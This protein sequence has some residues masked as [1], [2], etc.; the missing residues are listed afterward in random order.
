V[1]ADFVLE[2]AENGE[3]LHYIT[4]VAKYASE[5]IRQLRSWFAW[6]LFM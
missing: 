4:K 3:L 1:R 6:S 2:L 5:W